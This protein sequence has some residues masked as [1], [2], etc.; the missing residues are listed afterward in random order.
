MP[1]AQQR[2][3]L[4]VDVTEVALASA[5]AV[6]R[7]EVVL[8]APIYGEGAGEGNFGYVNE[9]ANALM[10]EG[11]SAATIEEGLALYNQAEDLILD[12]MPNIPMWFGR[13]LAAYNENVA[14]VV[15][16]KF[17]NLDLIAVTITRVTIPE[18]ATGW[19]GPDSVL[20]GSR[21]VARGNSE[22]PPRDLSRRPSQLS[23]EEER[24]DA[25]SSGA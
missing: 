9:D 25:T 5:L 7:G 11:N 1:S 19:P 2:V 6:D 4:V 24:W 16:D 14:N 13:T 8:G 12:D 15:V 18:P 3:D 23:T 20:V 10:A 17:G 22:R 21:P